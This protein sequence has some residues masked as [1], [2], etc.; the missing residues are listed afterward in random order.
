MSEASNTTRVRL[1]AIAREASELPVLRMLSRPIRRRLF[2]RPYRND[3]DYHGHYR[4]FAE[5]QA[6][7]RA[8]STQSL[9]AT[10]DTQAAGR[11]YRDHLQRIRVS[12]YPLVY[13]LR[14]LLA[15]GARRIF[16]LG[17]HVGVS[18]YGF[19]PYLDYPT[20]MAWTVHDVP[21]VMAAGR[22]RAGE[23]DATRQ[24]AF[25][26]S[27]Q[28][29]SGCDVLLSTGTLQYLDYTLPEL[30][31]QLPDKPAHILVNLTPMHPTRGF[32]TLQNLSIAICPY[33]VMSVTE[34]VS[35][36][37]ATGYRLV[38]Q[39]QSFERSLQVPFEPE[40]V[41]DGYYGFYFRAEG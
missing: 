11:M 29:A 2:R 39:W 34:F 41:V 8:L 37:Q 23:H 28:D 9:P 7:A 25:A 26:N 20:D 32:F 18:Y 1:N 4:T 15:D 16:D 19:R 27:A 6:A 33:R 35:G 21:A 12:D 17:G 3:N 10:Y 5:A 36:M 40:C 31:R 24:L 22:K 13:W 30:L 14:R 38:D